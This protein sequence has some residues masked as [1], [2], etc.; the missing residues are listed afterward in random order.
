M[1]DNQP[2]ARAEFGV[3]KTFL[4]YLW[5]RGE[6]ELKVRV[7]IALLFLVGAKIANV[8]VPVLYKYAVDAL[9]GGLQCRT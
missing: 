8:Y 9:D 6:F 1:G 2:S 4:P 7:V 3:V 5:P